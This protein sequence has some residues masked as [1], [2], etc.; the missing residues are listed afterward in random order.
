MCVVLI[1][2]FRDAMIDA[3]CHQD[4][5]EIT[6]R[7]RSVPRH[8]T[9]PPIRNIFELA[10]MVYPILRNQIEPISAMTLAVSSLLIKCCQ[11]VGI[12]ADCGEAYESRIWMERPRVSSSRYP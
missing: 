5:W 7:K 12:F 4:D 3:T 9:M 8:V 10:S 2:L 1:V 11:A 6:D